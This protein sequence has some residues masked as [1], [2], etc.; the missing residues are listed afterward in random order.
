MPISLT[1]IGVLITAIEALLRFI[2]VEAPEGSVESVVQGIVALVGLILL[3]VG[4]L[5]RKDLKLGLVRTPRKS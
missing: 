1:G 4:Q 5:R 2:G 3:I